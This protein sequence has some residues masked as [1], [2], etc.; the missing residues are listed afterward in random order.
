MCVCV[1]GWVGGWVWHPTYIFSYSLL[2]ATCGNWLV[3]HT[4]HCNASTTS[5]LVYTL[6][7]P[8]TKL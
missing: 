4:P 5:N 6:Q 7:N 1:D 2:S 8:V 3:V